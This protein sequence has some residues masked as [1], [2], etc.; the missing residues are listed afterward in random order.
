MNV[1]AI[2][3]E[4]VAKQLS[5]LLDVNVALKKGAAT[6]LKGTP[7]IGVVE[8]EASELVALIEFDVAAAGTLGAAL[9]RI[10]AGAVKEAVTRGALDESL[11][12]NFHE[13]ANVLTILTT[14]ALERRTILRG[15]KQANEVAEPRLRTFAEKAKQK[16]ALQVSVPNYP[17]GHC[18][19]SFV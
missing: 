8:D 5:A 7:V 10:P 15:I 18:R 9:S 12:A 4:V 1:A 17:N 19:F 16:V 13:V 11:L 14:A 6:D 2:T 3:P